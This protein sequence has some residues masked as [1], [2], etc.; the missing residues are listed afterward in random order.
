MVVERRQGL[1]RGT[2]LPLTGMARPKGPHDDG[3]SPRQPPGLLG[4][5]LLAAA[6]PLPPVLSLQNI[7][8][9]MSAAAGACARLLEALL[10]TTSP[11]VIIYLT[12]VVLGTPP[13]FQTCPPM[14]YLEGYMFALATQ[15]C[16][17][18]VAEGKQ[19]HKGMVPLCSAAFRRFSS[20][21]PGV[22]GS[23]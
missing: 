2:A 7:A 9:L 22:I 3:K 18:T 13:A 8:N 14:H 15:M 19:R 20:Q 23:C 6:W 4:R 16:P 5:L 17:C 11:F 1:A 12:W 10:L 21:Y